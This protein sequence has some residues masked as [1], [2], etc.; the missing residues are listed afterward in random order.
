MSW[1]DSALPIR[2]PRPAAQYWQWSL[3]VLLPLPSLPG[4]GVHSDSGA[5]PRVWACTQAALSA[6]TRRARPRKPTPLRRRSHPAGSR[7]RAP[8][9]RCAELFGMPWSGRFP[10]CDLQTQHSGTRSS[11]I[12]P[13]Y[14][15]LIARGD[16]LKNR[17]IMAHMITAD[18][19]SVQ[20]KGHRHQAVPPDWEGPIRPI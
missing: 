14:D 10:G 1:A 20:T 16:P 5:G 15:R 17:R 12:Q 7:R 13:M 3:S 6:D 4:I 19:T 8:S 2:Q 18:R 9:L 11:A